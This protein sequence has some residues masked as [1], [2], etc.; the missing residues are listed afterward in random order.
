MV[1][2]KPA[3][4]TGGGDTNRPCTFSM[5]VIVVGAGII[6]LASAMEISCRHPG[7]RILI[8]DKE[9]QPGQHHRQQAE[10]EQRMAEA[11]VIGH[12][13]H[14]IAVVDDHVEVG[15]GAEYGAIQQRPASLPAAQQ[16]RLNRGAEQRLG[17]RIHKGFHLCRLASAPR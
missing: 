13:C 4:Y 11:T 7:K 15:Q 1:A 2:W 8:L 12:L 6:G 5:R 16:G 3:N 10:R 14:G 9:N 17:D